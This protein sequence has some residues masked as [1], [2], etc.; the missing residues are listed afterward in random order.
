M[1]ELEAVVGKY[2]GDVSRTVHTASVNHGTQIKALA[3]SIKKAKIGSENTV[4]KAEF[5]ASE[6]KLNLAKGAI[7]MLMKPF[8][9]DPAPPNPSGASSPRA[10]PYHLERSVTA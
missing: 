1:P 2:T 5:T 8:H 10:E 6:T 7:Q 9:L 4:S 3:D